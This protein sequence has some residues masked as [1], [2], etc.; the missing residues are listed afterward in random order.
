MLLSLFDEAKP[1]KEDV[2]FP[3]LKRRPLMP[4]VRVIV[5]DVVF[6]ALISYGSML[7]MCRPEIPLS[8]SRSPSFDPILLTYPIA[9][10]L[11]ASCGAVT[12]VLRLLIIAVNADNT[13]KNKARRRSIL[14]TPEPYEP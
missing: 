14:K 8:V 13:P 5:C 11:S 2:C 4:G 6:L 9:S 7:D 3:F 10:Y 12:A 1:K